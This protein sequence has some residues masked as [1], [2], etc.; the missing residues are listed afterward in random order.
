MIVDPDDPA[1][2][3]VRYLHDPFRGM[4]IGDFSVDRVTADL[5]KEWAKGQ[6]PF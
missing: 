2:D 5:R 4:L 6:K 1:K 3:Q